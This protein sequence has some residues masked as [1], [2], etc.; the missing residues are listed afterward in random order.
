M[1]VG[2]HFNLLLLLPQLGSVFCFVS[3]FGYVMEA[4]KR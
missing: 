2:R 3:I 4:R 1:K